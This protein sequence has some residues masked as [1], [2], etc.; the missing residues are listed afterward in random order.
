[1][2]VFG[3][4]DKLQWLAMRVPAGPVKLAQQLPQLAIARQRRFDRGRL[5]MWL[6]YLS[7]ATRKDIDRQWRVR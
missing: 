6:G 1:M 3:S 5:I 7:L 2:L 4:D